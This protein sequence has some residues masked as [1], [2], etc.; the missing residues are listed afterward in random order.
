MQ[1]LVDEDAVDRVNR[2]MADDRKRN[3]PQRRYPPRRCFIG[4][5]RLVGRVEFLRTFPNVVSLARRRAFQGGGLAGIDRITAAGQLLG[6]C[7]ANSRASASG[8]DRSE[9]KPIERDEPAQEKQ[10]LVPP[11]AT[12]RWRFR[13]RHSGRARARLHEIGG[14]LVP[15]SRHR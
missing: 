11:R 10:A 1:H 12:C 3:P 9:P 6:I 13:R 4:P 8:T 14:Q 15:S 5:A 2:Q 7:A